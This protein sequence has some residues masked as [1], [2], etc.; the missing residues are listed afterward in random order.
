MY[1][2]DDDLEV[3]EDDVPLRHASR[4]YMTLDFLGY[5][6]LV[7]TREQYDGL[8][9]WLQRVADKMLAIRRID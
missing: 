4:P 2:I 3:T 7:L 6:V 8:P 1:S 5:A 9:R